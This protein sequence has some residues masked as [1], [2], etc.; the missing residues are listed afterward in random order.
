MEIRIVPFTR[1]FLRANLKFMNAEIR[2]GYFMA[3]SQP[4]TYEEAAN[5]LEY[6]EYT[7][8]TRYLLA[9]HGDHIVGNIYAIPRAEDLLA[10]TAQIGYQVDFHHFR[11]GIGS[12]L[13]DQLLSELDPS[14]IEIL[15][16]E[17]VHDNQASVGL[18]KKYQF[19]RVGAI[20]FGVKVGKGN[21]RDLAIFQL[22]I[23]S[24]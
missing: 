6:L 17:V 12:K 4:I 5:F 22:R 13:M 9:L 18:L 2:R 8:N 10:H 3:R 14:P 23:K 1:Q 16:A 20:S 11:Q 7:D 24:Q 21:Y 15:T 19:Q